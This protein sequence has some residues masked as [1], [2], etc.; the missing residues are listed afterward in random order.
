[1]PRLGPSKRRRWLVGGVVVVLLAALAGV[2]ASSRSGA[3]SYRTA[4]VE[5]ADVDATLDSLGTIQPSNQANLSFPVAGSVGSVLAAVGQQVTV[6][7][8]LA[9]LDTTALD[10]QLASARSGA[11]AAQARLASDQSSQTSGTTTAAVAPAAFTTETTGPSDPTSAARELVTTQQAHLIA[12]QHRADQDLATEQG[13]LK[14]ETALCQTFLGQTL[15]TPADGGVARPSPDLDRRNPLASGTWGTASRPA[16]TSLNAGGCE[17]AL[18]SVL[19]DQVAVEHDQQAVTTD[20]PALTGAVDKLLASARASAQPQPLQTPR[21]APSATIGSPAGGPHRATGSPPS[22]AARAAAPR[23]P[24]SA[25]QL[26]S[27]QAAIDAAKAQLAE[28]Q[29]AHDQAQLRSPIDGTVGSVTISAGQSVQG[30]SGT[31]QIV[32]I[33]PGSHQVSTSVSDINVGSVQV[34]DTAAVTPSGSSVPLSGQVVS[35]GLLASSGTS[36]SGGYPVTIG[37]TG[38]DQQLFAGQSASVSIRLAHVSGALTVPSSAVH[39]AGADHAV[40]VLRN[41]AASNVRVAVGAIGP[42]RTQVLAGLNPG[43]QVVLADLSQPLPTT[44]IQNV[45]RVAGG[46][47]GGRPGG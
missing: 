3:P 17:S 8:T 22:G 19:A 10:A 33:G 13:D 36:G 39:S 35:I 5:R 20:M 28:A 44:N 7:Q 26:A 21:P 42:T 9:A 30:S 41:G 14:T 23:Q 18:Q 25:E 40:T 47:G 2:L 31:P 4:S 24:A 11:A 43:D 37:L 15:L 6:G 1:M 32:V 16:A 29:Q 38:D 12:D 45:R 34:G 46:G 27:D